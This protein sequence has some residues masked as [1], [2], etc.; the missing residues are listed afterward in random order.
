MFN[1]S[2]SPEVIWSQCED[3]RPGELLQDI[4]QPFRTHIPYVTHKTLYTSASSCSHSTLQ[5]PLKS[6]CSITALLSC[7]E[8][9]KNHLFLPLHIIYWLYTR[10]VLNTDITD[11]RR[12]RFIS[13]IWPHTTGG[14]RKNPNKLICVQIPNETDST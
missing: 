3:I 12:K 7:S 4:S 1:H 14:G 13:V 10:K 8:I 5:Q 9:K 2:I 6:P 11:L